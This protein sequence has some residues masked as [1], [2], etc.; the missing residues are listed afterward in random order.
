MLRIRDS[1]APRFDAKTSEQKDAQHRLASDFVKEWIRVRPIHCD[2]A[3]A[4]EGNLANDDKDLRMTL[5]RV[6]IDLSLAPVEVA[7]RVVNEFCA[8]ALESL[9]EECCGLLAGNSIVRFRS[10]HRCRNEMTKMHQQDPQIF[11]RDGREAFYMNELDYC[12]AQEA[13]AALNEVVTAVYHSHVGYG[14][15][16]SEMDQEFAMHELFPFPGVDHIVI[17]TID[18]KVGQIGLF[19][20]D[21]NAK[22]YVGRA[23][24][25]SVP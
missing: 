4:R 13:A 15:Y 9:P 19:T 22:L 25:P 18:R 16:F 2:E 10:V 3:A 1:Q 20:W 12:R 5:R 7:G 8:H 24:L 21:A 23:V 6:D 17:S 11:P 14:A